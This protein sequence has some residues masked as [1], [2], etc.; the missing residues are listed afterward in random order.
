MF[1]EEM[2]KKQQGGKLLG[3][4]VY[5]CAFDPPLLCKKSL[6][7]N[8][9][10]VGKLIFTEDAEHE[11]SISQIL[12]QIPE[13]NK[14]FV[15][16]E[17]ICDVKPKKD[18]TDP[19]LKHCLPAKKIAFEQ[20]KQVVMPFGG[21]PLYNVPRR[22][23]SLDYFGFAQH[24]L[25]AGTLLLTKQIVHG[26]LHTKNILMETPK[27]CR[28]IDFG[29]AWSPKTLTLANVRTLDRMFN[30]AIAQEPP[31]LSVWNGLLDGLT[32][33]QT[34]ARIEDQKP[35]IQLSSKVFNQPI[36][37]LMRYLRRFV[38]TSWSFQEDNRYSFYKLYWAKVDAWGIGNILLSLFVELSM[39]PAFEQQEGYQRK[40]EKVLKVCKG[41]MMMDPGLRWDCA[42]ALEA[43]EPNSA[44]L[45]HPE[46]QNWLRR[47]KDTRQQMEKIVL[48][49]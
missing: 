31:E 37:D 10:K 20:L 41:L 48:D 19:D 3:Q 45:Q 16:I 8:G 43:W 35:G 21:K 9:H 25:E 4:G 15:I 14:Y 18:Q 22:F 13:A 6:T 46:V 42:E 29:L 12:K 17:D 2:P 38:E 34:L 5:G 23:A 33:N 32:L 26:D 1:Q 47:E 28:L 39:D 11:V 7:K 24:L 44:V 27:E 49:F 36:Q 30:P 40:L